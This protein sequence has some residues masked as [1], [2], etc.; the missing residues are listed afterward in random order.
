MAEKVEKA[1]MTREEM[2]KQIEEL[3]RQV[4][5]LQSENTILKNGIVK[6]ALKM[7]GVIQ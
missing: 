1:E 3:S 5:L 2:Q 6:M 4:M 7:E